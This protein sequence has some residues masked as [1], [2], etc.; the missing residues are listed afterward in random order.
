VES[1]AGKLVANLESG[2][3]ISS[4]SEGRITYKAPADARNTGL[5]DNSVDFVFS[6][7][8]LEHVPPT[9]ILAIM[10][11][12]KRIIRPGKFMFHS[13]NCGD[14]YAYVDK[15]VSQLHYLR[16]SEAAWKFWNNDFQ[17]QNRLRAVEIVKMAEGLG[18]ETVI[19]TAK[20]SDTRMNQLSQI[21]V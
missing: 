10:K 6:N 18:F 5:P 16:Y 13:V 3:D 21:K 7:S 14:H 15:K 9:D 8:V 2:L 1:E 12:S 11:E 20:A 4:A 19:N 17:Y